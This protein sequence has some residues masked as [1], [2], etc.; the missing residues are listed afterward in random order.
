[1][2]N[3]ADRVLSTEA[4]RRILHIL[5]KPIAIIALLF[6]QNISKFKSKLKHAYL[7]RSML[8]LYR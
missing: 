7:R 2:K 6:I 5:P 3:S 4:E 8:S 1:M